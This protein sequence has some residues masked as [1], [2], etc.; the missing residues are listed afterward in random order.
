VII[1]TAN[2]VN[3][4]F[5]V[6][7]ISS[8]ESIFRI[9]TEKNFGY[10]FINDKSDIPFVADASQQT[11]LSWQFY[12]PA[13]SSL[14]AFMIQHDLLQQ[15][16]SEKLKQVQQLN[17]PDSVIKAGQINIKQMTDNYNNYLIHYIDT[18]KSP[19]LSLFVL[20]YTAQVDTAILNATLVK[21]S[22]RF[23]EHTAL[24]T[25]INNYQQAQKQ[26]EAS[27][28]TVEIGSMAPDLTFPDQNDKP[29]SLSSLRGKYVLVDFWASW[30]GP[31]RGENPNVVNAFNKFKDKNF[32]ILGVSLD[33]EKAAWLQAIRADALNWHHISDLRYWNSEAVALY[34]ISAIPFNVLV[35][36]EGKI[37]A[38]ALTGEKLEEKL[39]EVLK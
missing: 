29:F 17:M 37:I 38:M 5:K 24:I 8:Q 32:T 6:S 7:G 30:C 27:A 19:D 39:A 4:K 20:G 33:K 26:K 31:C 23:P 3:G 12:T 9:R 18:T 36:P 14:K 1:D 34:H 2:L 16:I 15:Q 21:L 25:L 11:L 22:Q 10:V 13:N 28:S 35:D